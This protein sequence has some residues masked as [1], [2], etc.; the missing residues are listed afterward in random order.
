MDINEALAAAKK[1]NAHLAPKLETAIASMTVAQLRE[2]CRGSGRRL[3]GGPKVRADY[4]RN[5]H[6]AL[7]TAC[8]DLS[9]YTKL[10]G[11]PVGQLPQSPVLR[12]L[13]GGM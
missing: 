3:P 10:S 5:L 11:Y 13:L 4:V 2:E 8:H 1:Y 6:Q 9:G 12:S 7:T